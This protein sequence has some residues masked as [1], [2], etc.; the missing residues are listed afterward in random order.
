ML[1]LG[2]RFAKIKTR[3][4]RNTMASV[5]YFLLL[6][7]V[8][9]LEG[10]FAGRAATSIQHQQITP[11]VT[12]LFGGDLTFAYRFEQAVG[13]NVDYTFS[14]WHTI[15]KYDY[16][17]VNLENP[18]T[19]SDDSVKKPFVFRMHPR[20]LHSLKS[21]GIS[22]MNCAN[23]HIGDF[24][25]EGIK[26]TLDWLDS[27]GIYHVGAGRTAQEARQPLI[28]EHQGITIG[29]LGYGSNGIHIA[30]KDAP[31]TFPPQED[32]MVADIR[33]LR[34]QV[35]FLVVNIHWGNEKEITPTPE[36]KKLG[37]ALIDAG[38]DIIVGH[39]PHVLQKIEEYKHGLICYSLGNFIFGGNAFSANSETIVL[40]VV[41]N[42][43]SWHYTVEPVN[44]VQWRA[45]R[46]DPFTA[47]R[48]IKL[49]AERSQNKQLSYSEVRKGE[50]LYE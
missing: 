20:Y 35:D 49:L 48:I 21:A 50:K 17:M 38:A 46:A 22:I 11:Q 44:I 45:R 12:I 41:L 40:K 27:A 42:V 24:G 34:P 7:I 25:A 13:T 47:Q 2:G 3:T 9:V 23:N 39:H 5:F 31:G 29:F 30:K 16:M 15:G 26:E 1:F 6:W 18:I 43:S 33:A 19:F 37:H 32:L 8:P 4:E 10:Q 14:E 36:Q 28:L